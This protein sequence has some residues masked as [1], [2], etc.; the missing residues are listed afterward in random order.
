M[1]IG[2]SAQY[3][4]ETLVA[5]FSNFGQQSVDVFAPGSRVLSSTPNNTYAAYSGTSMAAPV[6]SG[7]AAMAWSYSPSLKAVELKN[8]LMD[9]STQY[10]SLL[11]KKPSEPVSLV[12]FSELSISGGIVNAETLFNELLMLRSVV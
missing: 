6:V 8:L 3:A 11:V 9:T 1:D 4:D 7:V 10:P 5:S 2:A 12:P